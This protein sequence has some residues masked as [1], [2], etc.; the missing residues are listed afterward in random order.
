M[1]LDS[2]YW[3]GGVTAWDCEIAGTRSPKVPGVLGSASQPS[4]IGEQGG[5]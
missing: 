2:R 5:S 3:S 1:V 4:R